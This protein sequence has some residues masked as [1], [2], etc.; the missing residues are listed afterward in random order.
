MSN[1]CASPALKPVIYTLEQLG[2]VPESH[3]QA[4]ILAVTETFWQMPARLRP[5]NA[6]LPSLNRAADLFPVADV[7]AFCGDRVACGL[8]P[9][10]TVGRTRCSTLQIHQTLNF[11]RQPCDFFARVVMVLLHNLCPGSFRVD[12][13]DSGR[14]WALPLLW[15]KRHLGLPQ[16]PGLRAPRPVPETPAG[17]D[18]FEALLLQMVSGGERML[19]RE[20]WNAFVRAERQLYD[21]E[22]SDAA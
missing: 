12:S 17:N 1:T 15:V 6:Y 3:W 21:A 22:H 16:G 18:A 5:G 10:M 19:S 9:G 7:M 8:P 14:C 20:D 4:F 2:T 13:S 11:H